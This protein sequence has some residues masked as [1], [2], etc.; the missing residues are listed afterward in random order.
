MESKQCKLAAH[1]F[2]RSDLEG[3]SIYDLRTLRELG[4]YQGHSRDVTCCAW[5]P[6]HEELFVSGSYDGGINYWLASRPDPQVGERPVW[7]CNPCG[8]PRG[9]R[10]LSGRRLC[11]CQ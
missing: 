11:S 4:T 6:V 2:Q 9:A 5:H 3:E 1:S 7:A 8:P 10:V